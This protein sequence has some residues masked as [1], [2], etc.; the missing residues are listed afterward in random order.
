MCILIYQWYSTSN[1]FYYSSVMKLCRCKL[2]KIRYH[3]V[4][5]QGE[6]NALPLKIGF[7]F[8]QDAFQ[9]CFPVLNKHKVQIMET[10]GA[11]VWV[12]YT[13]KTLHK[14][15]LL[16]WFKKDL[17]FAGGRKGIVIYSHNDIQW[18]GL[19]FFQVNSFGKE[20]DSLLLPHKGPSM[21]G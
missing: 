4:S 15:T 7:I 1:T 20:E 5:K 9:E 21:L 17:K 18:D 3:Q 19:L 16:F 14:V 2:W 6:K 13:M 8:N 10:Q 12:Q 11:P